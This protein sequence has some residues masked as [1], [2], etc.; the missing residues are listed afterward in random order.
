MTELWQYAFMK[1]QIIS[2][3]AGIGI[4]F[5]IGYGLAWKSGERQ[6]QTMA[7]MRAVSSVAESA[8]T[9]RLFESGRAE[10]ARSLAE[11][12]LRNASREAADLSKESSRLPTATPSLVEALRRAED[13]ARRRNTPAV[14]DQV[15]IARLALESRQPRNR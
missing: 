5:I 9:L 1:K 8:T 14:A 11:I 7:W 15:K 12:H 13:D 10:K 3:V 2:L 6:L 4:G